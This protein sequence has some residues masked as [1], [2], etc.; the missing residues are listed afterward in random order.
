MF[1]R[2]GVQ[3]RGLKSLKNYGQSWRYAQ[4][5]EENEIR[6]QF[7]KDPAKIPPGNLQPTDDL[8]LLLLTKSPSTAVPGI[9]AWTLGDG[10][11]QLCPQFLELTSYSLLQL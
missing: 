6:D 3:L 2:K 7:C 9:H 4:L 5:N 8:K 11:G 10:G 1:S